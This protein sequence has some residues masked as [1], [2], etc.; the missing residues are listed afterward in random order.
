V[1]ILNTSIIEHKHS[2][3]TIKHPF[4]YSITIKNQLTVS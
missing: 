1:S 4:K 2:T 3:Y